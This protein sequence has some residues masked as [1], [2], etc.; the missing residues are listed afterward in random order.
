MC[1]ISPSVPSNPSQHKWWGDWAQRC[2]R[3]PEI[4]WFLS[5]D[6]RMGKKHRALCAAL[7]GS[8][9]LQPAC[10]AESRLLCSCLVS[11][12]FPGCKVHNPSLWGREQNGKSAK[13]I[14]GTIPQASSTRTS[15]W[16]EG[17]Q[18]F[19]TA[20]SSW[21]LSL[22]KI[23][24]RIATEHSVRTFQTAHLQ[25]L[26]EELGPRAWSQCPFTKLGILTLKRLTS[27]ISPWDSSPKYRS[28][29]WVPSQAP[30]YNPYKK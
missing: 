26:L 6:A 23:L 4:M 17:S 12:K 1:I 22:P 10:S 11:L 9:T 18:P 20:C 7:A 27:R 8:A 30:T 16:V 15:C 2:G 21:I 25:F 5:H 29:P 3:E 28:V 24:P 19:R 14:S 13:F